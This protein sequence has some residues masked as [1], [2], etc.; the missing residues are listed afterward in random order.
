VI[1]KEGYSEHMAWCKQRS[2]EYVN[3]GELEN[4]LASFVSDLGKH[5]STA[6]D[7]LLVMLCATEGVAAVTAGDGARLRRFIEGFAS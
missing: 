7:E 6:G 5:E 1:A 3:S 4:A 2:L